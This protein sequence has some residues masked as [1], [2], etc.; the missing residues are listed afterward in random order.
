[1]EQ[2]RDPDGMGTSRNHSNAYP[3]VVFEMAKC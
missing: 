3:I 1:M 2:T